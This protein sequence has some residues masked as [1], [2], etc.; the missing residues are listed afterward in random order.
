MGQVQRS[1]HWLKLIELSV[2]YRQ[3]VSLC[4][5]IPPCLFTAIE[6]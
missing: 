6:G 5:R 2:D 3:L 1:Y 4:W